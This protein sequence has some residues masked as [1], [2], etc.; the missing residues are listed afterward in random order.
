MSNIFNLQKYSDLLQH[1]ILNIRKSDI[2]DSA[3]TQNLLKDLCELLGIGRITMHKTAYAY[4]THDLHGKMDAVYFDSVNADTSR[5]YT[6]IDDNKKVVKVEYHF[7]QIQGDDDWDEDTK[8]RINTLAE[9]IFTSS[10]FSLLSHY[11]SFT[12]SHDLRFKNMNNLSCIYAYLEMLIAKKIIGNF[13]VAFFNV[14]NFTDI[15]KAYGQPKGTEILEEYLNKA[16]SLVQEGKSEEK[17]GEVAAAGGDYGVIIFHKDEYSQILDFLKKTEIKVT[18]DNGTVEICS[19]SSHAGINLNLGNFTNSFELM[20]T[21]SLVINIAHKSNGNPIVYY[22]EK[23]HSDVEKERE[24]ERKF[25]NGIE[26]LEF[27]VYYQPKI[28]LHNNKLKGAEALVRWR[29]GETLVFPD[30]FIPILEKN[31]S[32]RYLDLYMLNHV[33]RHISGWLAE[34]KEPVQIS[35]NLS[36]VSLSM[37][38]IVSIITSIIDDYRI[39]RS[40]IQIEL[41][42]SASAASDEELRRIVRSFS[43]EEISTA[44]DDFGTGYSSLSLIKELPW[45]ML[46]IDKSLLDGAQE[47]DSNDQRMFKSIISMANDLGLECIVEGVETQDD[48]SLLKE[49][50]CWLAQGYFFSKTI[51]KTEFDKL[52]S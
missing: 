21:L 12:D 8:Q 3:E 1:F 28:D 35:V 29:Q 22:D 18:R 47:S 40:L 41:T 27:E 7:F 32:I 45:D 17:K 24:I 10:S 42:E 26:N 39:P 14:H 11:V 20:D 51:P 2:L 44:M 33:C 50:N 13:G 43:T 46:K 23:L 48:I 49:S 19:I 16:K 31:K 6:F 30:N 34:G 4:N 38:N 36:R 52:L 15:N 37:P 9:L 25:L 5:D